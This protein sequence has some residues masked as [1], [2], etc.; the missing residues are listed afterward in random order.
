MNTRFFGFLAAVCSASICLFPGTAVAGNVG[1]HGDNCYGADPSTI[2][3]AAGHT[4]VAVTTLDSSSLANLQGLFINGCTFATNSAVDSAVNNGMVLIWHDPNWGGQ[5]TKS[6]PGG[7]SVPYVGGGNTVQIDFPAGSPVTTGPGG[8]IDNSSL[9]N[10]SSSNHGYVPEASL[11]VGSEV[12]ATQ[13]QAANVTT[14]TYTTGAG[15][16]VFSTIPLT[17]YFPGGVCEGNVATAGM[18]AYGKNVIAWALGSSF[19][20]CAAEGFTGSRLFMCQQVCEAPQS[21]LTLNAY[22]RLYMM[23]YRQ[24]PPCAR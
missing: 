18:Q 1:Y 15:R 13:D 20:S 21:P 10:G 24:E 12:L 11:P 3:A 23:I 2:I 9:D 5:T 6:L 19:T 16:V 17:C 22:I 8:T 7:H 14:L 4:P